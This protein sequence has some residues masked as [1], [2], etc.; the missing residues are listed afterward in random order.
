MNLRS[1]GVLASR[2]CVINGFI[3]VRPEMKPFITQYREAKTPEERRFIAAYAI[4]HFPGLRPAVNGRTPRVTR[5]DYAD[6]YRDNW[7]CSD[8]R[9]EE[10]HMWPE[11]DSPP[12]TVPQVP[13]LSAEE[14]ARATMT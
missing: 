13:F 4:A 2:D 14:R 10:F 6:N 5:F 8:G 11:S 1:S 3:S 9:P 7:W 12:S